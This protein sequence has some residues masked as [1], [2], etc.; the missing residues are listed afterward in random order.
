MQLRGPKC[1]HNH[2]LLSKR[3][4]LAGASNIGSDY[5]TTCLADVSILL[6]NPLFDK[7]IPRLHSRPFLSLRRVWFVRLAFCIPES[8]FSSNLVSK[9]GRIIYHYVSIKVV[10]KW[11]KGAIIKLKPRWV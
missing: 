7:Y 2:W 11:T 9:H 5:I 3:L 6:S 10:I 1:W 4:N 8:R